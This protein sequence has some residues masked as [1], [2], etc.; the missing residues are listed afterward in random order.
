M[1]KRE[2]LLGT[3]LRAIDQSGKK[4]CH[5]S[6]E[7]VR[8]GVVTYYIIG[9]SFLE[10]QWFLRLFTGLQLLRG[11]PARR[12][13]T[14]LAYGIVAV[15]EDNGVARSRDPG[16]EQQ[17]AVEHN[18]GHPRVGGVLC[19][20]GFPLPGHARM[21]QRFQ[22]SSLVAVVE[23]ATQFRAVNPSVRGKH[24][25]PPRR[26][27][28]RDD[29]LVV[30]RLAG[31]RVRINHGRPEFAQNACD[32]ALPGPNPA[33]QTDYGFTTSHACDAQP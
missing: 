7:C 10:V 24:R 6:A 26:P 12:S 4:L 1:L 29:L 17:R 25:R 13:H 32:L 27:D 18:R 20:Q 9:P 30:Q 16:L 23:Y 31:Q 8:G 2:S 21:N 15:H 19:R 33:R 11:P 28:G 5:L 14:G 3:R 22:T